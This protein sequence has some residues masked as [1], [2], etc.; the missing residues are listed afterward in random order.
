[1]RLFIERLLQ[2]ITRIGNFG[3]SVTKDL[4]G[5][6]VEGGGCAHRIRDVSDVIGTVHLW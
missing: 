1:M 2:I 3:L 4:G 6:V 5:N